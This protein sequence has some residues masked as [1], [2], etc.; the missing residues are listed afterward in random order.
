MWKVFVTR[1]IPEP[2]LEM[3]REKCEVEVNPEDRVL[4]KEEIIE[5]VKGKDAL[6]CL[7]TDDIDEGSWMPTPT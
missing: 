5:G 4:T 6:L 2:G 3:L 7:L 1:R